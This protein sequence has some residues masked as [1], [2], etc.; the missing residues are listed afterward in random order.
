MQALTITST[1][2]SPWITRFAHQA[3]AGQSALDLACGAGRHTRWLAQ[4]G[5]RVLALDQNQTALEPLAGI[6]ET[7]C[8]DL[9][10]RDWPLG[11]Q[12]FDWI[13]VSNY[14]WRPLFPKILAALAPGGWLLYET[15]ASG[16]E[17]IGRP[18]RANFLLQPGELLNICANLRVIAF[19]DGFDE[20]GAARFVQRIAAVR[21]K[22]PDPSTFIKRYVLGG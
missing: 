22:N 20:S 6:S 4:R 10:S 18:T 3:Q 7:L 8:A 17:T 15:F 21:E 9:E 19:E 13:V 16:Q 2:P 12:Q 1:P 11:T 5:L 14:L